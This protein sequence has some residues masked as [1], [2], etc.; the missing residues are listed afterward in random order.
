MIDDFASESVGR[1]KVILA[2]ELMIIT[3]NL[4]SRQHGIQLV[5]WFYLI[6]NGII[7]YDMIAEWLKESK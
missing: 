3:V 6:W 7:S 5:V 1:I 4:Q 2:A